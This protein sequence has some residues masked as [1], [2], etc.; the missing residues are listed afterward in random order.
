[1]TVAIIGHFNRF[2]YLNVLSYKRGG[3]KIS[4][5]YGCAGWPISTNVRGNDEGLEAK[6]H[7]IH[8]P[9]ASSSSSCGPGTSTS[10]A[11]AA[12][13]DRRD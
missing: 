13:Q 3:R 8:V 7:E 12:A 6:A 4:M 2:G 11:A 5:P 10:D 9:S 1:V